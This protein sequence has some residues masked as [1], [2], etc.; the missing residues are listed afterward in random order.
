MKISILCSSPKHP[1][2]AWLE[3]WMAK[4]SDDYD[5]ELVRSKAECVGGDLL[6]L[7]SCGE[8][9]RRPDRKRYRHV[10]VLH[11]SDLPRGRGWNPHIWTILEGAETVTVTLLE[12]EDKLDSG[13]IWAQKR[14]YIPRHALHD[15]INQRLFDAEIALMDEALTLVD[16][17][18]PRPQSNHVEPTYYRLRQPADSELDPNKTIAEQ[19]DLMRVADPD[20]YPAFFKLH[21]H[22]YKL[23]LEK[24]K[25]EQ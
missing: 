13:R 17:V 2:N 19:F 5:I 8:I 22:I 21:G 16:H 10:L 4:W 20:R 12:A 7:V 9:L 25:D 15:E 24:M 18:Q 11:A 14:A 3:R 6:L 1:V 23:K